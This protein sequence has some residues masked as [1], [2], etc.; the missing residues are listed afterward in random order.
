LITV[1][2]STISV[3]G[4]C[5][6]QLHQTEQDQETG[7]Q[8]RH[9]G[10]IDTVMAGQLL[11]QQQIGKAGTEHGNAGDQFFLV[12]GVHCIPRCS[13]VQRQPG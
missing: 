12:R 11:G 1:L 7:Q 5:A 6:G 2:G 3:A 9:R 8:F 10:S 4:E 13:E